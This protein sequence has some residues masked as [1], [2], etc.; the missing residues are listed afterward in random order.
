MSLKPYVTL[1]AGG[2]AELFS[3]A[4]SVSELA[5][6]A[7][8]AQQIGM[9]LKLLG[10]GSNV[11][12]SDDGV[13]G[14]VIVNETQ[15]I[16]FDEDGLVLADTGCGFQELFLKCAQ[17][18]L[19]GLEYAVGIPGSVGGALASNAGAYRSSISEFITR[20]E[21][22]E[23]A[24][25]KWVTPDVLEFA[26]R[27]SVLRH[28]DKPSLIVLRVE[29]RLPTR[30]QSEI[31]NE[32][33]GYQRQRISK[34]PPSS[35]AGSFFKNVV[36][37][38]LAEKIPGLTEGMR[39]AGVVPAGFL[40]EAAGLKGKRHGGAMFGSRHANFLLNVS[41]AT[42]SE[43]RSLANHARIVVLDQFNVNLEEEVLYLGDWSAFVPQ[44]V[45]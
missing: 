2:K 38:E 20:L 6:W 18:G 39:T 43:L 12:P 31:Y 27:D 33:K 5:R 22:V 11:L 4:R 34:Q 25:R 35:S 45:A 40:L 32:A 7:V 15:M 23:N 10:W 37:T 28:P 16:I 29:M 19:G 24:K 36:D 9:N 26:Y 44:T 17:R 3:L 13:P 1:R 41:G 30:R 21:V 8:E 42:A 14:W